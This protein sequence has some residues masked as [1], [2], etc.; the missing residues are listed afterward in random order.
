MLGESMTIKK[1]SFSVDDYVVFGKIIDELSEFAYVIHYV[2]KTDLIHVMCS[3]I[4]A[5]KL[6]K[7]NIVNA[8]VNRGKYFATIKWR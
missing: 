8:R 3:M 1:G 4:H 5:H 6:D 2:P 7:F